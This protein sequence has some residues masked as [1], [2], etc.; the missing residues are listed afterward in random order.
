MKQRLDRG[1][2]VWLLRCGA[3]LKTCRLNP[4]HNLLGCAICTH[5]CTS[6]ALRMGVPEA[7]I[8]Q[9]DESLF[10]EQLSEQLP[11]DLEGLLNYD[12]GGVNVGRGAASTTISFLRDFNLK[13]RAEHRD[14]LELQVRTAIGASENYK[15]ILDRVMPDEVVM[16]NGRHIQVFPMV[17]L[18]QKRGI[19]FRC[20]E[21][22]SR[23]NRYH[24]FINTTPH[25]IESRQATMREMWRAADPG[26]RAQKA[27]A[28]YKNKRNRLK[29]N[30][31]VY[32]AG[33]DVGTLPPGF[34]ASV[35][36]VAIF[37]SSEDEMKTIREWKTDLFDSQNEAIRGVL[38]ATREDAGLHFYLRVHPNLARVDNDQLRELLDWDYPHL[39][40]SPPDDE[41]DTYA[42]V[43]AAD[44]V[45]TFGSSVGLEA[46]YWG[47]PSVLYG[48]SFY[49]KMD[50]VYQPASL[51]ELLALLRTPAPPA[52]PKENALPF[53]YYIDNY[54]TPFTY[55]RVE[56]A[57]DVWIDG[58]HLGRFNFGT[59][60]NF[61]SFLPRWKDWA[62]AHRIFM[63]R[64]L[65]LRDLVRVYAKKI[66]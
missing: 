7:R 40:I 55:S 44:V 32:T 35:H 18:C 41:V 52:K 17:D 63:G 64:G 31:Q 25:S 66:S 29:T 30:D 24:E 19:A 65:N 48:K 43:D 27:S 23:V 1:E 33:Q 61:L 14:M 38:E 46:T 5:R 21:F 57:N 4:T 28:W 8:L 36:N 53:A 37:N 62:A 6:E 42:L 22:G 9:L 47:T 51:T 3:A 26:E 54:G 50:V 13:P 16:Y 15:R 58:N 11:E 12:V 49:E 39:T 2:E 34:D 60:R 45:L 59:L 56:T 20:F 10:P